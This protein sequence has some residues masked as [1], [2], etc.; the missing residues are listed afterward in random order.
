MGQGKRGFVIMFD[1]D[2]PD[3]MF[4]EATIL[5]NMDELFDHFGDPEEKGSK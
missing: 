2:E 4:S 3:L 1:T 5:T